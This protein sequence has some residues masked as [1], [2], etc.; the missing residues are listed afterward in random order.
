MP[1][2]P[3]KSECRIRL[4]R[5][6]R[7]TNDSQIKI[8][9]PVFFSTP[10][11]LHSKLP[12]RQSEY[13]FLSLSNRTLVIFN[14]RTRVSQYTFARAIRRG[15]ASSR[16]IAYKL[17]QFAFYTRNFGLQTTRR[18]PRVKTRC[19]SSAEIRVRL[20]VEFIK[21]KVCVSKY[22]RALL[23]GSCLSNVFSHTHYN[24]YE[25]IQTYV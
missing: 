17:R 6:K 15:A 23:R 7:Y 1:K 4:L 24:S 18:I 12:C 16:F 25:L 10:H 8:T 20:T 2:H 14:R 22:V 9:F 21:I 5:R 13:V 11:S 19:F 3:S